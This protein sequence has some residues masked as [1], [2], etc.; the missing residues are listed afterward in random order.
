MHQSPLTKEIESLHQHPLVYRVIKILHVLIAKRNT[1]ANC[2]T[3]TNVI[4]RRDILKRSARCFI[5]LRKNHNSRE[6]QSNNKCFKCGK[7]HHVSLC[8]SHHPPQHPPQPPKESEKPSFQSTRSE[9]KPL[10]R[11]NEGLAQSTNQQEQPSIINQTTYVD[12]R[13]SILLQTAK[14]NIYKS[15]MAEG[16]VKMILDSGSQRSYVTTRLKDQFNL[17][18]E[19]TETLLIKTFGGEDEQPQTCDVVN[20]TI[21]TERAY[22]DLPPTAFVVPTISRPLRQQ[23]TQAAQEKYHHLEELHLADRNMRDEELEVDLLVG[24]DQFWNFATGAV[25]R[26]DSG[27]NAMETKVGW[28][29]SGPV[30]NT[31]SKNDS[32]VNLVNTHV[33]KC[34]TQLVNSEHQD[35]NQELRRFWELESLVIYPG[36]KSVYERFTQTIK[37]KNN[38]YEVELP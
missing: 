31:P 24:S 10:P 25:K 17:N 8:T 32:S 37:L 33:L 13:T 19:G 27:P 22:Q 20:L 16:K 3:V 18:T 34:A 14:A 28:V 21:E 2:K 36:N 9:G 11:Y 38:R 7:R 23:A 5:C 15:G 6:C 29:L 30:N 35:L 12:T 4:A 1:S 26:G